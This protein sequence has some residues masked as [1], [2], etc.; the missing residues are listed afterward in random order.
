MREI[1]LVITCPTDGAVPS[2]G[3]NHECPICG[4]R[5]DVYEVGVQ[6]KARRVMEAEVFGPTPSDVDD[7]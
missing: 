4:R 5:C 7:A 3:P 1:Q 6:A 2:C